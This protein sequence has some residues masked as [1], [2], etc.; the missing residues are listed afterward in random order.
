MFPNIVCLPS[1]NMFRGGG[2]IVPVQFE[3]V[4]GRGQALYKGVGSC[5]MGQPL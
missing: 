1:L 4:Q 3:H 2:M 5:M